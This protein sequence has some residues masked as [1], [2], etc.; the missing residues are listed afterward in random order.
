MNMNPAP[1]FPEIACHPVFQTLTASRAVQIDRDPSALAEAFH[2]LGD[3]NLLGLRAPQHWGGQAW[4]SQQLYQFIEALTRCSGA[5]AF[6]QIQHQTAVAELAKSDNQTLKADYLSR[7]A[8]GEIGVG[9]G[10]SHLRRSQPPMTAAATN[11]GFV[12]NGTIPWI[13]GFGIFQY[14][15]LAAV[16]PN[17]QAVFVLAPFHSVQESDRLLIVSEPMPLAALTSTQTVTAKLENWFV[18]KS[19][20]VDIKPADWIQQRDRQNPLSH[21]FFCLGCAQAGLDVVAQQQDQGD[22]IAQIYDALDGELA[23]CRAKIYAAL[24]EIDST[25][26]LEL[27]AWA[28]DVMVRCAHAAVT[29]SRGAA[30]SLDHPAQRIYRESLAFTVFGQTEDVMNASLQ[31][32]ARN[33]TRR[34]RIIQGASPFCNLTSLSLNPSP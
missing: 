25:D 27:R 11:D 1:N 8:S 5:L 7:A 19:L 29:V 32:M 15:L 4:E 33:M 12:F 14:A 6:L 31:Y 3:Y 34:Q 16:L 13:T 20:V 2:Q 9:I 23:L 26:R 10:Y 30:A 28:I 17:Q 22:H 21:S 24:T 18:P